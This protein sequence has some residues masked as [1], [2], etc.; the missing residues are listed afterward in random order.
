MVDAYF[1]LDPETN[2]PPEMIKLVNRLRDANG[3]SNELR[4]VSDSQHSAAFTN[5]EYISLSGDYMA[6]AMPE[7]Y[8]GYLP[9]R[10]QEDLLMTIQHE[11]GHLNV[12]PNASV[13]W[14]EEI[15]SLP[16]E[17][18]RGIRWANY[19]SDVM[20][21]YVTGN[22]VQLRPSSEKEKVAS[23]V[24]NSMWSAYAGGY[25]QC[26]EANSPTG[27]SGQSE[28]RKLLESGAL[29]DNRYNNGLYDNPATEDGLTP[30]SETPFFQRWQGHGRGPQNYTSVAWCVAHPMPVGTDLGA[31]AGRSTTSQPFPDNWKQVQV[32]ANL[33][34]EYSPNAD[35]WLGYNP[36]PGTC[37]LTGGSTTSE[38][39][40][41]AGTYTVLQ[42]RTYDG[43][44]N[45]KLIRPIEFYQIDYKGT[46]RWIPAHYCLTLCPHCG[47]TAPTQFELAFG[48]KPFLKNPS[49]E[50]YNEQTLSNAEK[51]RL[52]QQLINNL[53]AGLYATSTEG[54]GGKTGVAA[55]E[56]WLHDTAWDM[57][58]AHT[59]N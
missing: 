27:F 19:F 48:Y 47:Q 56:A 53:I 35:K 44:L 24:G 58:L 30:S 52:Y 54:Y 20:V 29:V 46:P 43:V 9:T 15:N 1:E 59:G 8:H 14:R 39:A 17:R 28:H 13:G 40:L 21:N 37:P 50:E 7:N 22:G 33:S 10:L 2:L 3:I 31:G 26:F 36:S 25:R 51:S 12:H 16:L 5:M 34:I 18:S 45:T 38:G 4:I 32:Q 57:H 23:Q 41:D 6:L 11:I 42:T 55:G 49:F